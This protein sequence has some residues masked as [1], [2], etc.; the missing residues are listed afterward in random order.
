M[1]TQ[2][3]EHVKQLLHEAM[4]LEPEQR[5]RFLDEACSSDVVLREEVE[6][7]LLADR[8][9]GSSFFVY[10]RSPNIWIHIGTGRSLQNPRQRDTSSRNVF[11]LSERLAKVAWDRYGWQNRPLLCGDTLR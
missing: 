1:I 2:P 8:E 11:N 5:G 10:R 3:W 7:L 9:I 4:Q 6:S